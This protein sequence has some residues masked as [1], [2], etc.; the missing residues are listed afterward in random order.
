MPFYDLNV[1]QH[2][3]PAELKQTLLFL[4]ELGYNVVAVTLNVTGKLPQTLPTVSL[5]ATA[6]TANLTLLTRLTLM[7]SDPSQNHRLASLQAQYDLLALR[8]TNE[9]SLALCCTGL[10]CDLISLDLSQR[11]PFILKFKTVSAAL[12]RGVRFEICYGAGI[13]GGM[14]GD[15]RRNLIGGAMA[16]IRAT[17]GRGII[18]SSEARSALA[19]RGPWDVINLA[20]VWGLGQERGKEAIC[21]E[22]GKVVRLAQMKRRSYRG[23][24][25]IIDGVG[26]ILEEEKEM[27]GREAAGQEGQQ[28]V[29]SGPRPPA[30]AAVVPDEKSITDGVGGV[31]RKASS[32]SITEKTTTTHHHEATAGGGGKP[33][34]KRQMK[35]QAKRARKEGEDPA[36]AE[37][38]ISHQT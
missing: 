32:N 5:P 17:R 12:K 3:S 22:A 29:Q 2:A 13:G 9:K 21:E 11:L 38:T 30:P 16:L 1:T 24:V 36:V 15:A 28:G 14:A 8:P 27:I 4:H 23:V 35:R 18:I 31:K 19:C 25:D 20:Q 6:A 10:D 37:K 34:S 33:L 26:V 7:I